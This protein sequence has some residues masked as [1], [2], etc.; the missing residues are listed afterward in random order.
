[1]T[2]TGGDGGFYQVEVPTG[3]NW[4]G[5][6]YARMDEDDTLEDSFSVR[7][8]Q[9]QDFHH[10]GHQ[11]LF[12]QNLCIVAGWWA[13]RF[14]QYGINLGSFMA[15][16]WTEHR[17]LERHTPFFPNGID[18]VQDVFNVLMVDVKEDK[19][20]FTIFQS[21]FAVETD[22]DFNVVADIPAGSI[23]RAVAHWHPVSERKDNTHT[24]V[25]PDGVVI[26]NGVE[27]GTH[28]NL[29]FTA[30]ISM[31]DD[32][33]VTI[34]GKS[35]TDDEASFLRA[36]S[37]SELRLNIEGIP[38]PDQITT[39][40]IEVTFNLLTNQVTIAE[41]GDFGSNVNNPKQSNNI[42]FTVGRTIKIEMENENNRVAIFSSLGQMLHSANTGSTFEFTV[43]SAG[44]Y[45]VRVNELNYKVIVR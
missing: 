3:G 37:A 36:L 27:V 38:V 23:I 9:V 33:I 4:I 21:D 5:A 8:N 45:L 19:T 34:S 1:M 16:G 40:N 39:E 26:I 43:N 12:T 14:E 30:I 24:V 10:I 6:V 11:P 42:V 13:G 41:A 18:E 7:L 15:S 2:P 35:L 31:P 22:Q 28:E 17:N 44:I 32:D 20:S 25:L 29:E